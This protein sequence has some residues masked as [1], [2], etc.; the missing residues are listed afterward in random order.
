M[1]RYPCDDLITP[2]LLRTRGGEWGE[3]IKWASLKFT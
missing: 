2:S 1:G 3:M